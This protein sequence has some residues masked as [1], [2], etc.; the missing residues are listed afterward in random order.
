MERR[1]FMQQ[2]ILAEA[3][4]FAANSLSA[5]QNDKQVEGFVAEKPF[6]SFSNS[7]V[8]SGASYTLSCAL[9]KHFLPLNFLASA[10]TIIANSETYKNETF[11]TAFIAWHYASVG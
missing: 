7:Y 2:S 10:F 8:S 5:N 1:K 6:Y 4:V 3:S 11:F 9:F